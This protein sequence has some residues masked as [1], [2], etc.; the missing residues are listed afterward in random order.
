[1]L[2]WFDTFYG[3]SYERQKIKTIDSSQP[4]WLGKGMFLY[5]P[6]VYGKYGR[7]LAMYH[8]LAIDLGWF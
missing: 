4:N 8:S 1:M 5:G 7:Q 3:V 2:D 6:F